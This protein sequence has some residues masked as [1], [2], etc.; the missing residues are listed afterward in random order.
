MNPETVNEKTSEPLVMSNERA[1]EFLMRNAK[2]IESFGQLAAL[3]ERPVN[4]Y[5]TLD[6]PDGRQ[7]VELPCRRLNEEVR[8]RVAA[9]LRKATPPM[10]RS[11]LGK[12]EPNFDDKNYLA[13]VERNEKVARAL[14]IY[15]G[16]PAIA[17]EK[18]GLI[19]D[20]AIY[21]FIRPLLTEP[22]K[23]LIALTIQKGGLDRADRVN[24]YSPP[25]SES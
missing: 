18:P 1:A 16:C 13:D 12:E 20:E 24:F 6:G 4:C 9:I 15:W 3:V 5:F 10:K 22:L 14:V 19:D 11:A 23:E 17:A 25:G 21:Q 2:R 8:D 7:V